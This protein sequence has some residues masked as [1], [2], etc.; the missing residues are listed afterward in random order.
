MIADNAAPVRDMAFLSGVKKKVFV[1]ACGNQDF[2]NP[3]LVEIAWKTAGGVYFRGQTL[4]DFSAFANDKEV[5]FGPERFRI[6]RG[7]VIFADKYK[8]TRGPFR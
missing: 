7:K 2:L 4:T 5:Q 1:V 3:Q 8:S 6:V